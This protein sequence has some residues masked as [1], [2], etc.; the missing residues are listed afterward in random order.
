MTDRL[1]DDDAIAP[2][3]A[4]AGTEELVRSEREIARKLRLRPAAPRV[5]RLSRKA[6]I[7][8]GAAA[9]V[10]LAFGGILTVAPAKLVRSALWW[11][12]SGSLLSLGSRAGVTFPGRGK[13]SLYADPFRAKRNHLSRR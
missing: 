4:E 3:P 13:R 7:A 11:R 8:L 12:A 1:T 9:S 5:T 10:E 6:L 2:E